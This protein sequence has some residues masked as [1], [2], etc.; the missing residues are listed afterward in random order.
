M[1]FEQKYSTREPVYWLIGPILTI[2]GVPLAFGF[3]TIIIE[4]GVEFG[5]LLALTV[6]LAFSAAGLF[7]T[8]RLIFP[9]EFTTII[10]NEMI[11]C[12]TNGDI[13]YQVKKEDI[14]MISI[15]NDQDFSIFIQMHCGDKIRF[16]FSV[17]YTTFR[18]ELMMCKYPVSY[19]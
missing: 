9:K 17:N 4:E 11:I 16:P 8:Y 2:F 3:G 12:K 13:T 10:S 19:W 7:C 6:G 14:G 5:P 1:T 18:E 15:P